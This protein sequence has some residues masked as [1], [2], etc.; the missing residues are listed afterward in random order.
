MT[1]LD[2]IRHYM[3]TAQEKYRAENSLAYYKLDG[4]Y[5]LEMINDAID[6]LNGEV[7]DY[8]EGCLLDNFIVEFDDRSPII[9]AEKYINPNMSAYQMITGDRRA[10]WDYWEKHFAIDDEEV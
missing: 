7:V 1:K 6:R 9:F 8:S 2:L 10:V 4:Y 3:A 5:S